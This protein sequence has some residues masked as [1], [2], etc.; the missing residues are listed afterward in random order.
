M[1]A[2]SERAAANEANIKR[3]TTPV[4]DKDVPLLI[5]TYLARPEPSPPKKDALCQGSRGRSSAGFAV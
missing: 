5:S 2:A 1:T 3:M 4:I